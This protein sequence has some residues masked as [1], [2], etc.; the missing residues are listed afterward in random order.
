MKDGA[1][2]EGQ[3]GRERERERERFSSTPLAIARA[4]A[5]CPPAAMSSTGVADKLF[6][7][8]TA[9]G[10]VFRS[11]SDRHGIPMKIC[12]AKPMMKHDANQ[13]LYSETDDET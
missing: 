4:V 7:R 3:R 2:R 11:R 5:A 10:L 6:V 9:L 12:I 8:E 13:H 1:R